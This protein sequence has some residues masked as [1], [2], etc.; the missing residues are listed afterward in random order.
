M[1]AIP[2]ADQTPEAARRPDE[3]RLTSRC[4]SPSNGCRVL[5]PTLID[6]KDDLSGNPKLKRQTNLPHR[7]F[8][9][10]MA[11]EMG[12]TLTGYEVQK[13]LAAVDWFEAQ[14]DR[15]P[16]LGVIGYGDGGMRS[17]CTPAALDERIAACLVV[18][19]LRPAGE[20]VRTNRSTATSGGCSASSATPNSGR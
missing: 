9:Y 18:G 5:V 19:R 14:D 4:G 17:R 7:E 12:R 11:Y 8:I 16:K 20:P 13:V 3:G 15:T 6:R 2:H 1:V 10:R